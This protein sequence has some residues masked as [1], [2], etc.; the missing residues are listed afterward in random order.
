MR[1]LFTLAAFAIAAMPARAGDEALAN[2]FGNTAVAKGGPADTYT[3]YNANH[4]FDLKVP[5]YGV[6]FTG[7]WEIQGNTVCRTFDIPPP[8]I[9]NPLCTPVEAHAV[10]DTWAAENA[11]QKLTVTLIKGTVNAP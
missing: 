1:L 3:H 9:S 6:T 5:A 8:G 7:T 2:Y 11:G 4:T 10:G